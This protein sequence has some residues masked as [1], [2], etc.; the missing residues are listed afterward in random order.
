MGRRREGGGTAGEMEA[1]G[2]AD[3]LLAAGVFLFESFLLVAGVFLFV[4][5][6]RPLDRRCFCCV[7]CF[8]AHSSWPQVRLVLFLKPVYRPHVLF[9][10]FLEALHVG[11]R[12]FCCV[13]E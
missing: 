12:S 5:L 6:T 8:P 4:C 13:E 7:F 11:R 9:C 3:V 10:S 2:E 1:E